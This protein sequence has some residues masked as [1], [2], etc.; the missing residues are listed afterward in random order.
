[1][2]KIC[3][4]LFF[5]LIVNLRCGA[6]PVLDYFGKLTDETGN[7]LSN[8]VYSLDFRIWDN[9]HLSSTTNLIWS[10]RYDV[11]VE[12]GHF[13]VSLG[14]QA[15]LID[16]DSCAVNSIEYAFSESN[17]YVGITLLP[18]A[19]ELTPRQRMLSSPY[20]LSSKCSINS[21]LF[22][23][24]TPQSVS[25]AG[26]IVAFAG[27]ACPNGWLLCAGAALESSDYP[28]LFASIG[29]A[30]GDASDDSDPDTDFRL[31]DCRGKFLRA[32]SASSGMD[33]DA[34]TRVALNIGGNSGNAVGSYQEDQFKNHDHSYKIE[35]GRVSH[36][37]GGNKGAD[38]NEGDNTVGITGGSETRPVNVFV[39]YI[40]KY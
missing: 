2:R 20:A 5:V 31:P 19:V 26:T 22:E 11:A 28:S 7:S 8:G 16:G 36:A 30:W 40:I 15:M 4:G 37:D 34:D 6:S 3:F 21:Y 14:D 32:V 24:R 23:G 18:S 38:N 10:R 1:M 29:T 13:N 9:E 27:E 33:S 25:P 35:N 39:N 17:R 12:G